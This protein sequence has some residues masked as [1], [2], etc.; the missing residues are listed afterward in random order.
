MGGGGKVKEQGTATG[1]R[2]QATGNRQ[3]GT[4]NRE[5]ATGRGLT[6]A[7]LGAPGW[8]AADVEAEAAFEESHREYDGEGEE[9]SE[10]PAEQMFEARVHRSSGL[11]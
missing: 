1:N 10:N 2:E 8:I 11:R 9:G 3:Q 7:L 6:P 4:G 5:Q